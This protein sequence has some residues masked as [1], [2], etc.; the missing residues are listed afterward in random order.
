MTLIET[1]KNK[2]EETVLKAFLNSLKIGF[3]SE[4]GED[5]ALFNAMQEGRKTALLNKK[6]K[7]EFLKL[8]KQMK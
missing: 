6:E 7:E 1:R 4:A 3:H 8:G 2:N 5:A